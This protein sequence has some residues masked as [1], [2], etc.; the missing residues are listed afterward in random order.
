MTIIFTKNRLFKNIRPVIS[1]TFFLQFTVSAVV[2]SV[3][4]VRFVFFDHG[5][6]ASLFTI[7]CVSSIL[8]EIIPICYFGTLL[9]E[10]TNKL[11]CALYNCNWMEQDQTFRKTLIIFMERS[12]KTNIILA[13]GMVPINLQTFI[14]VSN[15]VQI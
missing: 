2:L 5:V 12:Q 13:G 6:V 15:Q 8:I 11:T 14:S 3:A 10:H 1:T 9:V 7:T 4:I